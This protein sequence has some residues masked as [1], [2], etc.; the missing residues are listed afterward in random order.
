M[1]ISEPIQFQRLQ[2]HALIARPPDRLSSMCATQN[3]VFGNTIFSEYFSLWTV[4]YHEKF[5][6]LFTFIHGDYHK[7]K[8]K[9]DKSDCVAIE[10][11]TVSM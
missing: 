1:P 3:T 7:T 10:I 11:V 8:S 4:R 2:L 9:P 6:Y 5:I